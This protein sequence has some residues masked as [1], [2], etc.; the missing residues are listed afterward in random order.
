MADIKTMEDRIR[1]KAVAEYNQSIAK[2]AETFFKS[3]GFTTYRE[4]NLG[5]KPDEGKGFGLE[6]T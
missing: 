4:F 5:V 1:E 2:G 3:L 6:I